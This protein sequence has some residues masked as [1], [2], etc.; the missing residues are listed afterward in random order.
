MVDYVASEPPR[1][2]IGDMRVFQHSGLDA[3]R[4]FVRGELPGPP[5][6]RLTGLR[7]TE[8]SLGKATFTMPVTPWLEDGF[9]LYW[10]GVYAL[11]ADA[12]L[13]QSSSKLTSANRG[14]E[15]A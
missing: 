2:A 10:G 3:F 15:P 8:A 4:R 11:L 7:P 9:G 6:A 12:P 1:G 13:M 5:I 14:T